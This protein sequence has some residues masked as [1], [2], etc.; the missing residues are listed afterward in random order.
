MITFVEALNFRSLHY[1]SQ[2]LQPLEILV[3][4][5]ASGKT[6]FLDVFNFMKDFVG[7]GV[8]EA[9]KVR[10]EN[11]ADLVWR[12]KAGHF[13]LAIEA[14]VPEN[15]KQVVNKEFERI[16]YEI[17]IAIDEATYKPSIL[18]ERA[19]F[20]TPSPK[21]AR[22]FDLFPGAI[23]P[24]STIIAQRFRASKV[25]VNKVPGG[26]DNFYPE[27][28]EAERKRWAHAYK[29]GPQRSALGNLPEDETQFPVAIW[30]RRIL[31][32]GIQSIVL[33][34]RLIRQASPPTREHGFRPDGSD[35]PWVLA[36]LQK[37]GPEA[38][39]EW[40]AHVRTAL[41]DI[42]NIQVTVQP[43]DRFAYISIEYD[44]GVIVPSWT[45]SDGT[46]RLLALTALAYLGENQ[47]TYLIEE[48]ENG[49]HPT[50]VATIYQSL[51]SVYDSQVL[52]ATHSP[53]LISIAEPQQILCFAKNAEGATDIVSGHE[54]PALRD[55]K[56][57]VNLSDLYAA[58]VLG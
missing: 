48:P 19:L 47:G 3:G 37:T 26:H 8:V 2:E 7:E 27:I 25:I 22:N 31:T 4:P 56:H 10:T 38:F 51:A 55:W 16:R 34:S 12:R 28:E 30:F 17:A 21:P 35:L 52:V 6:A 20:K 49:I 15:L 13:E 18:S 33:N 43:D 41:P 40:L 9:I 53:V 45:V 1:V 32:E 36:D 11:P 57:D 50:A 54:H 29:L 39:Q 42:R 46:L 24:P 14:V 44:N 23:D 58:G 5:N